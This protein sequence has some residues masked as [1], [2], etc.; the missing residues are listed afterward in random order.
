MFC[1]CS[2]FTR[3]A[4]AGSVAAAWLAFASAASLAR[5]IP[6]PADPIASAPAPSEHTVQ[7]GGVS[8]SQAT[9][10]AQRRYPGRVVRAETVMQG[11]RTV[12]EIRILGEDGRVRTVRIDAQTGQFL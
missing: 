12:H 8:L 5:P 9:A 4:C 6:Q 1:R 11:G 2:I 3:R 7:R 10:M